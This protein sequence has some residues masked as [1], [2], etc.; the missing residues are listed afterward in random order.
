MTWSHTLLNLTALTAESQCGSFQSVTMEATQRHKR[1]TRNNFLEIQHTLRKLYRLYNRISRSS[2]R[3]PS[4]VQ[5]FVLYV[6]NRDPSPFFIRVVS[7]ASK[8]EGILAQLQFVQVAWTKVQNYRKNGDKI[9]CN[10][11]ISD[12]L[13]IFI[14]VT[15]KGLQLNC[16]EK[17]A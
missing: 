3:C 12:L 4:Q 9:V 6:N 15:N 10:L 2:Y 7:W 13:F 1:D 11:N 5:D 17:Q 16:K 8:L 14:I